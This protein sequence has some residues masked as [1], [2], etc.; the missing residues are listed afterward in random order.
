MGRWFDGFTTAGDPFHTAHGN[1]D[2]KLLPGYWLVNPLVT[3]QHHL[4]WW[5]VDLMCANLDKNKLKFSLKQ[6]LTTVWQADCKFVQSAVSRCVRLKLSGRCEM[7]SERARLKN[8]LFVCAC[9]CFTFR[10][11]DG[12]VQRPFLHPYIDAECW[13]ALSKLGR[14]GGVRRSDPRVE[15]GNK[16][17]VWGQSERYNWT[18]SQSQGGGLGRRVW[19]FFCFFFQKLLSPLS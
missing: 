6:Q 10:G 17:A 18:E 7:P 2:S 3:A 15:R 8:V 11:L 16:D 19:L 5:L 12:W 4:H 9:V 14:S 1:L 13:K